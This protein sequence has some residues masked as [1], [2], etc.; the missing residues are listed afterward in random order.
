MHLKL[1]LVVFKLSVIVNIYVIIYSFIM[2][3]Y[4]KIESIIAIYFVS[5]RYTMNGL[6]R[7]HNC[8]KKHQIFKTCFMTSFFIW[9]IQKNAPSLCR[10]P[11]NN[12]FTLR[13]KN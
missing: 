7:L 5:L 4:F 8:L 11:E 1:I 13:K 10:Y 12:L 9:S 2:Y 6:K 3:K